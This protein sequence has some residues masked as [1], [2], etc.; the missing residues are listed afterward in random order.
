MLSRR[1]K[2]Q[3]HELAAPVS[4]GELL[5]PAEVPLMRGGWKE[6]AE[7][8]RI[9]ICEVKDNPTLNRLLGIAAGAGVWGCVSLALIGAASVTPAAPLVAFTA[10]LGGNLIASI[11]D[12]VAH[13]GSVTPEE[14]AEAV[15]QHPDLQKLPESLGELTGEVIGLQTLTSEVLDLVTDL[16]TRFREEIEAE[17]ASLARIEKKIDAIST[18]DE[19]EERHFG[20]LTALSASRKPDPPDPE[21]Q[22][23]AL[24]D[25]AI[26][27]LKTSRYRQ[28][29]TGG[30][31][32]SSSRTDAGL[33]EPE[34][35][36]LFVEPFLTGYGATAEINKETAELLRILRDPDA[37]REERLEAERRLVRLRG[38][39]LE[40]LWHKERSR[41][42]SHVLATEKAL[43]LLGD[44]GSGKTTLL[45]WLLRKCAAEIVKGAEGPIPLLLP[46]PILA[47]AMDQA[48]LAGRE[49]HIDPF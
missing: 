7:A 14:F 47:A 22:R 27:L 39:E 46:L 31:M 1:E 41:A 45:R 13:G 43:V 12:R 3:P 38:N 2:N 21:E 25:Y 18:R 15:A 20:V 26:H 33:R 5:V 4:E 40:K 37:E 17:L 23:E 42:A 8:L 49:F 11:L 19:D 34:L 32:A 36:D 29:S 6:N 28:L 35:D 9:G 24:H 48:A 30:I 16:P 10:A 44:P